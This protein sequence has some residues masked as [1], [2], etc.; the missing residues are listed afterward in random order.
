MVVRLCLYVVYMCLYVVYMYSYV[1][2]CELYAFVCMLMNYQTCL[3]AVLHAAEGE[4]ATKHMA[5]FQAGDT[6]LDDNDDYHPYAY[7]SN[8]FGQTWQLMVRG[9]PE[10]SVNIVREHPRTPNLLFLGHQL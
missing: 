6:Q 7:V 8:D 9:L 2:A 5:A 1:S 10:T 3:L 4:L